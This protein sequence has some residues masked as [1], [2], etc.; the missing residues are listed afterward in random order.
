MSVST[1]LPLSQFDY[2]L[3]SSLIAQKPVY[4][5]DSSR[6]LIV[7][8]D[9]S[10]FEHKRFRDLPNWVGRGD[11]LVVN[12]TKVIPARIKFGKATGGKGELLLLRPLAGKIKESLTWEAVG[13]PMKSLRAGQ[14]LLCSGGAEIEICERLGDKLRVSSTVPLW[15]VIQQEGEL[16]LPPYIDRPIQ[17]QD[18]LDYQ[19]LFAQELG[20]VAAPTASLHFTSEL[21]DNLKERGV[22]LCEIVL[23]VGLGTFAPVREEYANDVRGHTMHQEMFRVPSATQSKIES[24]KQKGGRVVAVGTTVVRALE[25]WGAEGRVDGESNLFIYPEYDF[26]VVDGLITNFHLPRSTLLML[27]AALTGQT[28]LKQAYAEAIRQNYRFF[29]YGDAMLIL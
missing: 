28:R 15:N 12:R 17:A 7:P 16:P 20:A 21:L 13:R 6:L 14:R 24:V 25:T 29:S 22:E 8:Q 5:R 3:P 26:K 23:H 10:P 9:K 1:P 18:E 27:V 19:S 4:P 2:D 11:L